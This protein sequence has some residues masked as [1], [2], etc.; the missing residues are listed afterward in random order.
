MAKGKDGCTSAK[1]SARPCGELAT[2]GAPT[3][4]LGGEPASTKSVC[5]LE[6]G[7]R[8]AA[9]RLIVMV[10]SFQATWSLTLAR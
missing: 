5:A 7:G 4:V 3:S 2:S 10:T 9:I 1:V 8:S 6:T